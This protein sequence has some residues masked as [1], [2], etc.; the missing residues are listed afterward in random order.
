MSKNTGS[1]LCHYRYDPLDRLADFT[2]TAR[3][4]TQ[5]FYQ[6]ER[7]SCEI[8]GTT[9]HSIVQQDEYLLAQQQYQDG[10]VG[11]TDCHRSAAHGTASARRDAAHGSY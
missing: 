10:N 7:L 3:A 2:Q 8:Q 4:G 6:N 1:P 11:T 5:R 9:Q